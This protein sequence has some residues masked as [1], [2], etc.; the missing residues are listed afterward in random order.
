MSP[1]FNQST[2]VRALRL[3]IVELS[4]HAMANILVLILLG[5][6]ADK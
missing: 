2:T 6:M 3:G 5:P 4:P 1:D